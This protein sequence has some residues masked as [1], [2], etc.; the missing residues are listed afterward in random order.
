MPLSDQ[1][2]RGET[3]SWWR[4]CRAEGGGSFCSA[5]SDAFPAPEKI[6]TGNQLAPNISGNNVT[7]QAPE[8]F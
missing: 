7:D 6:N 3:T 1:E 5:V 4:K 8:L 2:K